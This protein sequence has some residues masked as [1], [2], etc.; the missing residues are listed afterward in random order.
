M[1][2]ALK[3]SPSIKPGIMWCGNVGRELHGYQC[4]RDAQK[5]LDLEQSAALRL[6][7]ASLPPLWSGSCSEFH[8]SHLAGAEDHRAG[9]R[10][11]PFRHTHLSLHAPSSRETEANQV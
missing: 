2:A 5:K 11:L 10:L 6:C 1:G 8:R 3:L 7:F 4:F 9:M